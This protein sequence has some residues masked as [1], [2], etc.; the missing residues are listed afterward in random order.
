MTFIHDKVYL[1]VSL[2]NTYNL[3][4]HNTFI[5]EI[6]VIQKAVNISQNNFKNCK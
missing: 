3:G 4:K 1:F 6:I 5:R 2:E